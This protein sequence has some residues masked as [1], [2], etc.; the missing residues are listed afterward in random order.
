MTRKYEKLTRENMRKLKPGEYLTELGV[1]YKK[2]KNNDGVFSVNLRVDGTRIRRTVGKDSEG[3]TLSTVE[4]YIEKVRT[5]ARENRLNLPKGRKTHLRFREA[6]EKYLTNLELEGGK[7]II[8]KKQQL[9]DYLVPF[10]K[11]K[12]VSEIASFD[13]ERYKKHTTENG[14]STTTVNRQL[15]VYTHMINKLI[16]W[17]L[18]DKIP[19]RVKKFKE[20]GGRITY[21]TAD[22]AEALLEEAKYDRNPFVYPFILIGLETAM[23]RTEILSI[24]IKDIDLERKMIYIPE[25]KTGSREQPITDH[26]VK[27]LKYYLKTV[28]QSQPWL[29]PSPAAKSGHLEN[30]EKPFRRVVA[31]IGLDPKEVVRHTLRHTAI[32]HL[33]QAGVDLPTVKRISGHKTLQ[34]V[35]RYSH[36][37]GEHIRAALRKLEQR[38]SF[39]QTT[40]FARIK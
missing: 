22:Q 6:A 23:R 25:A 29:F 11:D 4:T 8:R 18:L 26:L 13:I 40:K 33:V 9:K 3:V 34:M 35:E 37:N 14:L 12:V 36:Q 7:N 24:A 32:T 1:V 27:F 31:A 15:A 16:D 10:F 20:N 19:C 28:D 2:Q 39:T 30:I 21:L 38:Y 5:E 17:R